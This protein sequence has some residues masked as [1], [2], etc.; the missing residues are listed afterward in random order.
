MIM[1]II[2]II[3]ITILYNRYYS[4]DDDNHD[5]SNR[6]GAAGAS[7]AS[8]ASSEPGAPQVSSSAWLSRLFR[9]FCH[10]S[11]S[12]IWQYVGCFY[13]ASFS[14]F[15]VLSHNTAVSKICCSPLQNASLRSAACRWRRTTRCTSRTRGS[16]GR[17]ASRW[18]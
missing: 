9:L 13:H 6:R 8:D 3:V 10:F 18:K 12:P 5:N 15:A 17:S 4:N 11:V 16:R 2:L 14:R 7:G 1:I